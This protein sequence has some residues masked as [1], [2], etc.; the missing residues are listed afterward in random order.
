MVVIKIYLVVWKALTDV[1]S[2]QEQLLMDQLEQSRLKVSWP[3]HNFLFY[4]KAVFFRDWHCSYAYSHLLRVF[5]F[6]KKK[7]NLF[8][9]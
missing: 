8:I 2:F 7:K 6:L 9:K 1:L 5:F 4:L 3:L